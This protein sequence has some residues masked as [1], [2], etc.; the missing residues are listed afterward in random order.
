[1]GGVRC[2][3][4]ALLVL[5]LAA[6]TDAGFHPVS[7]GLE[8]PHAVALNRTLVDVPHRLLCHEL[9]LKDA[10]CAS[11][12]YNQTSR[13]CRIST[14]R[15][16]LEDKPGDEVDDSLHDLDVGNVLPMAAY[17][18]SDCYSEPEACVNGHVCGDSCDH[19]GSMDCACR[20]ASW[21]RQECRPVELGTWED[22][23]PW[24]DCSVSCGGGVK[25]R[26]RTCRDEYDGKTC[27]GRDTDVK[28]C[29]KQNCPEW[30]EWGSWTKC[31]RCA[32]FRTRTRSCPVSGECG[33]KHLDR[34]ACSKSKECSTH[35]RLQR[36]QFV[37]DGWVEVWDQLNGYWRPLCGEWTE[38]NGRVACR[39]LGFQD[40][41]LETPPGVM[42]LGCFNDAPSD[43]SLGGDYS[44]VDGPQV[45][46][47]SPAD[48][49]AFC[50]VRG[51]NYAA[52]RSGDVC[53]CGRGYARTEQVNSTACSL[54]C[55]DDP[56]LTCGSPQSDQLNDVYTHALHGN[57][58]YF[59]MDEKRDEN[60]EFVG[61][62]PAYGYNGAGLTDGVVGKALTLNGNVQYLETLPLD[63]ACIGSTVNCEQGFSIGM[64]IKLMSEPSSDRYFLSS[65]GHFPKSWG[66]N[67]Y[68]DVPDGPGF[69][70][71]YVEEWCTTHFSLPIDV[72]MYLVLSWRPSCDIS[73]YMNSTMVKFTSTPKRMRRLQKDEYTH[74]AIGAPNTLS[75]VAGITGDFLLDEVRFWDRKL[76]G[77]EI[78]EVMMHDLRMSGDHYHPP[79]GS[80]VMKGK[81]KCTGEEPL[82]GM[83]EHKEDSS[84]ADE[85][86]GTNAQAFVRCVPN[87]WWDEWSPWKACE[88]GKQS[89]TRNC[90]TPSPLYTNNCTD[91]P[92][93]SEQI[94]ACVAE[95]DEPPN[96]G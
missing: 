30:G 85:I 71:T 83:C 21:D 52:I 60:Q 76:T 28:L 58:M 1:M 89:R 13:E 96:Q 73:I 75:D 25:K 29:K 72:W 17:S 57:I 24:G 93:P 16:G 62:P 3:G 43:G 68:Y 78:Y 67:F 12:Q 22:W 61:N 34:S 32:G 31:A 36:G 4:G 49:L 37:T 82:L 8:F 44:S 74:L 11:F 38:Q 84:L 59:P 23:G 86:C 87:G 77:K 27:V 50:H 40:A 63:G 35:V 94:R 88:N 48:C 80:K 26:M 53:Q 46:S 79:P 15:D 20:S 55:A 92:G 14:S 64:W 91:S 65:G 10:S 81:F 47:S 39:N 42:S 41:E 56:S 66:L 2:T 18:D 70:I 6:T 19:D 9:C 7:S 51:Y 45:T 33:G 90:Y 5:M 95:K 69:W 54:P